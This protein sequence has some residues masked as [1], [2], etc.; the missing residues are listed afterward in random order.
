[1][2][3]NVQLVS[4]Q[5]NEATGMVPENLPK[6]RR[7]QSESASREANSDGY[8]LFLPLRRQL[9][10]CMQAR[11]MAGVVLA[12]NGRVR[13]KVLLM[14]HFWPRPFWTTPSVCIEV[15][16]SRPAS[17]RTASK[18]HFTDRNNDLF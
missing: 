8:R 10:L 7:P 2:L 9:R 1:M 18:S 4:G 11:R 13:L 5:A 6:P 15:L 16:A 14:R 3:L 17:M 12:V